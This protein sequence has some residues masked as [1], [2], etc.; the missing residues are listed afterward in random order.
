MNYTLVKEDNSVRH[1]VYKI[2]T[3]LESPVKIYCRQC[4]KFPRNTQRAIDHLHIYHEVEKISNQQD[5]SLWV[6]CNFHLYAVK[7]GDCPVEI[8]RYLKIMRQ[9]KDI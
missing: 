4:G 5:V 6:D 2:A 8:G 1:N 3:L 7:Q 9:S